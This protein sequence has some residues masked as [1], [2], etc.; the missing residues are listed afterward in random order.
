MFRLKSM[1]GSCPNSEERNDIFEVFETNRSVFRSPY[2]LMC[3]WTRYTAQL[4]ASIAEAL[5]NFEEERFCQ[6]YFIQIPP[7]TD[8]L[9]STSTV[10]GSV[11]SGRTSYLWR[12]RTIAR[13]QRLSWH[14]VPLSCQQENST[15]NAHPSGAGQIEGCR[16]GPKLR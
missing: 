6:D 10:G 15:E 5:T 3:M 7:P 13:E 12:T 1:P 16:W 8:V 14:M 11:H 2:Y 4:R 9:Y